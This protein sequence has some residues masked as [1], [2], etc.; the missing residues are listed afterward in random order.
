MTTVANLSV[1]IGADIDGLSSGLRRAEGLIDGFGTS[2]SGRLQSIGG[3]MQSLGGTLTVLTAPIMAFGAAGLQTAA[4]FESVMAQLETFGGLAPAELEKV[5]QAALQ[6]GADTMFSASDAATA[7]LELTKA[8]M[9]TNQALQVT[10]SV[11]N[12]AAAGAMSLEAAAGVLSTTLSQFRLGAN[13]AA[14]AADIIARAAAASS[15][16]VQELSQG[17]SNVGGVA[18]TFG[19][20]LRET[21]AALS[22]F[23]NA[24]IK[25]AEAGTQLKSVLLN[26]NSDTATAA[27]QELG[28]SLY[29]ASG[30]ARDFDTVIDDIK[31]GLEGLPVEEQ[32]RLLTQM[33]GSYGIVGLQ[34]LIAAGGIDTMM[35]AMESAPAA[36]DLAAGAMGTFNGTIEA[37]KGSV[38]T[39]MIEALTPLMEDTLKPL[40]EDVTGIVNSVTAWVQANPQ[41]AGQIALLGAGLV[42]L[43]PALFIAGTAISALGT[44]ASAAATGLTFLLSPIGL[45]IVGIPALLIAGGQL[46]DFLSDVQVSAGDAGTA[47]TGMK[48]AVTTITSGDVV[49]GLQNLASGWVDLNAAVMSIPLSL[50]E[51]LA[52]SVG[53]LIGVDVEGGLGA[54]AGAFQN[55]GAALAIVFDNI[56]R[57]LTTFFLESQAAV[58]GGIANLRQGILDATGVDIAP[59]IEVN[60]YAIEAQLADIQVADAIESA[61]SAQ[62]AANAIDLG[63]MLNFETGTSQ[64]T[65]SDSLVNLINQPGI[66]DAMSLTAKD[67]LREALTIAFQQ[68]D[69]EG[70]ETLIPLAAKLDI[71][72][73][74]LKGQINTHINTAAQAQ[75]YK[76]ES[77][78]DMKVLPGAIDITAIVT[79]IISSLN[80]GVLG[81]VNSAGGG[82]GGGGSGLAGARIRVPTA[83]TGAQVLS[84][85][86]IYA[87]ANERVLNAAE[88]RQ[89]ESGGGRSPVVVNLTA[90]GSDP[91][92]L[93]QMVQRAASEA[94][95]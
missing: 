10:P 5:R 89:Y 69:Q 38:E 31:A 60:Q 80:A 22:V 32:N 6:M 50:V 65:I 44:L 3:G 58:I 90:Y 95:A 82:G 21:A 62:L 26:L 81:A 11:L 64:G 8:G 4:N 56:Q 34:A 49:G 24:G 14:E 41:L 76:A 83:A 72:I 77:T 87:H 70:Q 18:K 84:D 61:L 27:L 2:V 94:G 9:T 71:P 57:D 52:I 63:A 68:A 51:N 88:T 15:A 53:N 91:Y 73:D 29:D 35:A 45:L 78:L 28:V 47:L 37:L 40:I 23:N 66:F 30:N 33:G 74:S 43:G 36:A 54:W 12:L 20:D 17:L 79:R 7:M 19:L 93:W 55:A 13:D 92:D 39:L 1:Q 86:L 46:D 16:D 67:R 85:G 25:G 48:D 75:I 59:T 42:V